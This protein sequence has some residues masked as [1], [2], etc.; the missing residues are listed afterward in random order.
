MDCE[1]HALDEIG[2]VRV[3]VCREVEIALHAGTIVKGLTFERSSSHSLS[4]GME[5]QELACNMEWQLMP[6]LLRRCDIL[7][8]RGANLRLTV[9][10]HLPH[11]FYSLI[12][13]LH[14]TCT[15]MHLLL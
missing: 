5:A 2:C 8:E 6:F 13:L 11:T 3:C 4:G 14:C 1:Q 10:T 15:D 9:R 12:C 7:D